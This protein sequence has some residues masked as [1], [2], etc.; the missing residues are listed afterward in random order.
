MNGTLA[1]ARPDLSSESILAFIGLQVALVVLLLVDLASPIDSRIFGLVCL[2]ALMVTAY[3]T[4]KQTDQG[5]HPIFLFM[6][7]LALFQFGRIFAWFISGDWNLEWF[8]LATARP[9]KVDA[10]SVK[11]AM[12]MVPVSAAF[13][14]LGFFVSPGQKVLTF[15]RNDQ[16]RSFF[17]WLYFLTIPFVVIKDVSYLRYTLEHGGY[18][19][20]YLGGGEHLEQVGLPIRALALLNSIA[21]LPYLILEGRKRWLLLAIGSYLVVLVLELL[22]GLRGKFFINFMFL[23][24][25]YNIKTGSSFKP[26]TAGI[27]AFGLILA[28]IGAEI[29]RES[30]SGLNVNLIEYFFNAQGVS[31]FVTLSAVMYHD[32]F[33]RNSLD[34]L[35]NQF[36]VPF[37]HV[38]S[39]PEGALLTLDLTRFLNPL[40]AKYGFG[41]GDAYLANLYLL[42]GYLAVCVGSLLLGVFCARITQARSLFWRTIALS[43]LLWVPYLPRSGY[44]EPIAI[45]IK[46]FTMAAFGFGLYA[47]FAW[48]KSCFDGGSPRPS[49][50]V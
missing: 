35:L 2:A 23:W 24:M 27:G 21:F 37:R 16:M 17:G 33:G 26:I 4:W 9:F 30:K 29:F 10:G 13:V 48:L 43:I 15:T 5:N 7:F 22:V 36:L 32:V 44:L 14:Y 49:G 18:L 38:N 31:F 3:L 46:Y 34:Y 1:L 47:M 8:D 50:H 45:S 39:F 19:A 12:L 41:T 11:Q 42:G 40:A 28:A 20:T 25:V 6:V